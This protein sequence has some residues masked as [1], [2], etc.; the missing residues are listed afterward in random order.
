MN[1]IAIIQPSFIPWIGYFQII[2]SCDHFIFYDDVQ[3][4]RRGWRN[5]NKIMAANGPQ[6]LT[7]PVKNKGL[8]LQ[9]INQTQIDYSTKWIQKSLSSIKSSYGKTPFFKIYFPW[10]ESVLNSKYETISELDISF[11]QDIC[12]FLKISVEFHRSSETPRPAESDKIE[13]LISL[14]KTHQAQRYISGPSAFDYIGGSEAFEN[15][16]IDLQYAEY[17]I[18][19]DQNSHLS[20]LDFLFRFGPETATFTSKLKLLT[21]QELTVL[22]KN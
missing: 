6:W 10:I 15:A 22:K 7:V 16:G 3:Y 12:D 13:S 19:N 21:P 14:C 2:S 18:P 9:K 11:T 17:S 5:R 4:D 20:I 8:Y 1:T